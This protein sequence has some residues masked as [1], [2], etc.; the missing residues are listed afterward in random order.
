[1]TLSPE[2]ARETFDAVLFDLDGVLT[3]TAKLHAIAWKQ[4][5]DEHLRH[6]AE[7][8][9]ET[10]VPF[11]LG[12]DYLQYVDGKPRYDGV[13]SFLA[14]RGIE[15]PYG[16]PNDPPTIE[17]VC[18]IGNKKNELVNQLMA[19]Q[20]VEAYPG[21]VKAVNYLRDHGFETAVVS[22]SNNCAAVLKSAGIESLFSVF[23]DGHTATK[24]NLAGKPEPDTFLEAARQLGVDAKRCIVVEDAV[25]GVE[26]GKRGGFGL[27]IGVARTGNADALREHGA[28]LVVQD[29]SELLPRGAERGYADVA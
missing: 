21:S 25:A 22:S 24:M 2:I 20:G 5:F 10:F 19:T 13:R 15:L 11:D 28:D 7:A 8:R 29:L 1:M 14:S 27:V 9:K 6:R 16:T 26:A 17:T 18:G 4:T 3:A 12:K 23:V